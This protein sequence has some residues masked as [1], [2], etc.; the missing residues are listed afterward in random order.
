M[1][2]ADADGN[3][4]VN[5]T[6]YSLIKRYILKAILEFPGGNTRILTP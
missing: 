4:N 5:S 1:A 3:G 6:D 2:A